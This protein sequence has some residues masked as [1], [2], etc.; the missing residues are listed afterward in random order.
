MGM[1]LKLAQ[2]PLGGPAACPISSAAEG[3]EDGTVAVTESE[4]V[5][6][7]L[8]PCVRSPTINA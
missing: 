8:H 2:S 3:H 4:R 1:L 5:T 6:Q 7:S